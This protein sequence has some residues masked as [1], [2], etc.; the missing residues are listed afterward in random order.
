MPNNRKSMPVHPNDHLA[1][2]R[3]VPGIFTVNP[4]TSGTKQLAFLL[5]L[6]TGASSEDEYQDRI[7]F[8]P[9]T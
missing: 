7:V 5:M 6:I 9:L 8:L 3:Q 4:R 2:G 1:E